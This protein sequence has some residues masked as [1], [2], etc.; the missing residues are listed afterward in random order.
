MRRSLSRLL[1][2]AAAGISS[3]LVASVALAQHSD[4]ELGYLN[5]KIAIEF[6]PEG[7]VFVGTFSTSGG[8]EQKTSNPGFSTNAAEGLVVNALDVI[9]YN[10]LGPLAYH[11]GTSFAAVPAGASITA[12]DNPAGALVIDAQTVGPVSGPRFIGQASSSGSI[13]SHIGFL[14]NPLSLD[15]SSYGA[16]GLRMELTTNEPGILNSDPFYIVFNF[17]LEAAQFDVAVGAFA[18]QVP[19]PSMFALMG[20]GAITIASLRRRR[21]SRHHTAS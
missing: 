17:G 20:L 8:L 18:A 11:N 3:L 7:R 16:Y 1:A 15:A 4:V 10:V 21:I 5:G 14:L 12:V 6:G 19:E 2:L 13:H 9:D